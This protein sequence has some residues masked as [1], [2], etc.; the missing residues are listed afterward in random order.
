ML[1]TAFQNLWQDEGSFATALLLAAVDEYAEP[2]DADG[3]TLFDWHPDTWQLELQDD[4]GFNPPLGNLE[5]L[6]VAISL[7]TTNFFYRS[8][9]EFVHWCNLLNG[10]ITGDIWEPA[11]SE[12]IAWGILEA[13]LIAPPDAAEPEVF[14]PEIVAYIGAT[15]DAEGLIRP[16]KSLGF[17][18]RDQLAARLDAEFSDDP[19][20]FAGIYGFEQQK[21]EQVDDYIRQRLRLLFLQLEQLPLVGN[22]ALSAA[23]QVLRGA[24]I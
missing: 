8:L 17:I 7:R 3:R 10:D 24:T 11:D 4:L 5:K 19:G 1:A 13:V 22:N 2:A 20:L 9:P 21:A 16:P 18:A 12:D 15:L 6:F 14:D 23:Q